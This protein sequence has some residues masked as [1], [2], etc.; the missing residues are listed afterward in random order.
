MG[1]SP[2]R[3]RPGAVLSGGMSKAQAV[4]APLPRWLPWV[5]A[6]LGALFC[7]IVIGPTSIWPTNVDW[8]ARGDAAQ[9]Y[10][11]WAFFRDEPWSW[12]LGAH[13]S[14][15]LEQAAS[16]VYTD[17]IPLLALPL[18]LLSDL[19]P[20]DF[21]YIG[22]W[23][24][25]CYALQGWLGCRLISLFTDRRALVLAGSIVFIL[26]PILLRR[27]GAHFALAAHWI[28]LAAL[29]LFHLP[30]RARDGRWLALL[31]ASTLVHAYLML[32]AY[33]I[34]AA[35]LLHHGPLTRRWSWRSVFVRAGAAA[36]GSLALMWAAGY[37]VALPTSGGFEHFSMNLLAPVLPTGVGPFLVPGVATA[38]PGQY[39]GFNYLGLG[40]SLTLVAGAA[41]MALRRTPGPRPPRRERLGFALFLGLLP[42]ALLAITTQPTI[43]PYALFS[44]RGDGLAWKV[45]EI[46]R[47]SG[48]LFW[49]IYYMLV[50]FA[51][52]ALLRLPARRIGLAVGAML[53][54]QVAD[55]GPYILNSRAAFETN[56]TT[57]RFPRHASPFWPAARARYRNIYVVP[58]EMYGVRPWLP[59][60]YL[61]YEHGFAIDNMYFARYPSKPA[62]APRQLRQERLARGE[63]HSDGLYLIQASAHAQLQEFQR[64]LPATTGVGVVDGFEVVA[65]GWFDAPGAG[66]LGR[67]GP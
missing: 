2:T 23:L 66:F 53:A 56:A 26:S 22:L 46:F 39:E 58:G 32:M 1:P 59:H 28:P 8:L 30:P 14:L 60:V 63:L 38:T 5:A 43:G 12:P 51:L 48:R 24:L 35:Y 16:I 25:A 45:F 31:W 6:A 3:L 42:L 15:G 40:V 11:G 33:C 62:Q 18:K 21:Q 47:A 54:L 37:F 52:R 13:H 65:P 44:L 50:L 9:S 27:S 7:L 36:G 4:P 10:M 67:P 61:A 20:R 19:L 49:P 29:Y 55:L 34:Y 57:L 17:S 64:R 41:H